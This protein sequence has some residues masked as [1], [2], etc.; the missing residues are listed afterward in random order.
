MRGG[1]R[2]SLSRQ[3]ARLERA[4]RGPFI[5]WDDDE[6]HFMLG[7][8]VGMRDQCT[9]PKTVEMYERVIKKWRTLIYE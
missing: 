5:D 3:V 6:I 2:G 1:R 4:A 9:E 7:L 8:L